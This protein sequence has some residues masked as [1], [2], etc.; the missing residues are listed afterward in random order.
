MP[1]HDL[2]QHKLL[3]TISNWLQ[4]TKCMWKAINTPAILLSTCA[5][6]LP[7][8]CTY[9]N[10]H[11]GTRV[12]PQHEKIACSRA[13]KVIRLI[14]CDHVRAASRDG[15]KRLASC[16]KCNR[17]KFSYSCRGIISPFLWLSCMCVCVPRRWEPLLGFWNMK[18]TNININQ[19][20]SIYSPNIDKYIEW[21]T[22]ASP[23][24]E[25]RFFRRFC[26]ARFEMLRELR[27]SF[28]Q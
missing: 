8:S 13:R 10:A 23:T 27:V 16:M 9:R 21:N 3:K 15:Q 6:P 4:H 14:I 28:S 25:K 22:N 5:L 2:Y 26:S 20:T 19:T 24:C 11:A 12:Q 18:L 17:N 7:V 1:V